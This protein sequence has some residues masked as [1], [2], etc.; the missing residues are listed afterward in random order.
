MQNAPGGDVPQTINLTSSDIDKE[1][2]PHDAPGSESKHEPG[3]DNEAAAGAHPTFKGKAKKPLRFHLA[4]LS[5]LVM[6]F[7][8]CYA[9]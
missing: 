9:Q 5:L 7:I 6:V 2:A 4:F 1:T 3:S 8:V